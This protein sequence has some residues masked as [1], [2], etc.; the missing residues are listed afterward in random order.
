MSVNTSKKKVDL[1]RAELSDDI[2]AEREKKEKERLA[3]IEKH[4]KQVEARIKTNREKIRR[5]M[6]EQFGLEQRVFGED[7]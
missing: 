3:R 6:R 5:K 7:K 1:A 4:N 2:K